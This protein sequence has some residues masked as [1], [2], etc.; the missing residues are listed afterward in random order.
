MRKLQRGTAIVAVCGLLTVAG[1]V[2]AGHASGPAAETTTAA[3]TTSASL[4]APENTSAPTVSG[5]AQEKE[6]LK[7]DP[8]TWQSSTDATYSY[9]WQRCDA[10]G[11]GC[12]AI[13][14]ATQQTY[15]LSAADVGKTVRVNVT[16]TNAVGSSSAA[17]APTDSVA[18]APSSSATVAATDVNLPDRLVIDQVQFTPNPVKSRAS[19][20]TGR[21]HVSDTNGRSVTGA[22]VYMI[23]IPYNRISVLPETKSGSDGWASFQFKPTAHFP[24]SRGGALVVFVRARTPQGSLLAGAS[25][26]RLV[27]LNVTTP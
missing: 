21:F 25:T 13:A 17:S 6:T 12:A 1:F 2:G 20:V 19:I 22:L 7:A 10:K 5:T 18:A 27:Q 8:G 4:A 23:G 16:A 3:T 11:A 26:R 14:N 24:I 9:A 15:V